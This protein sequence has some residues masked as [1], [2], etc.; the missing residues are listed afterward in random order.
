MKMGGNPI[1]EVDKY[2]QTL[3]QF[4]EDDNQ[5]T[6]K[7]SGPPVARKVVRTE[8]QK[9]EPTGVSAEAW[10]G[11]TGTGSPKE[12]DYEF[13]RFSKGTCED[14]GIDPEDTAL[15][16]RIKKELNA[17]YRLSTVKEWLRK[18]GK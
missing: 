17:P 3:K 4:L 5:S 14:L 15:L 9:G 16:N 7:F 1:T 18:V 12:K 8:N 11:R 13:Q 6:F 2:S 10:H